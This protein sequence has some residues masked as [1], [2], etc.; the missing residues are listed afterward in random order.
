M[1]IADRL[2]Y[3]FIIVLSQIFLR[4]RLSEVEGIKNLPQNGAFIIASNHVN[5]YDPFL[6]LMVLARF[7]RKNYFKRKKILYFIGKAQLKK[8]VYAFFLNE[9][10]GFIN[11]SIKGVSRAVELLS[12]GNIVGIFPEG[13]QDDNRGLLRAKRGVAYVSLLSGV[14]V[15]PVA[16]F[17]PKVRSF[18]QGLKGL[19]VRKK[20]HFGKPLNFSPRELSEL[21]KN[22]E[23]SLLV[24][25]AIMME[26]GKLWGKEY[27]F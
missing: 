27:K 20:V 14:P 26:I 22:P 11:N 19:L 2:F 1:N 4:P 13:H 10:I 3:R 6:I 24:T 18:N 21:K 9:N 16:C 8:R 25:R 15:I 7:L 12:E 23:I 17:G 5:P